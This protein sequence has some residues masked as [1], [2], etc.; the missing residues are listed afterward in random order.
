[1]MWRSWVHHR[2]L[3]LSPNSFRKY[4]IMISFKISKYLSPLR[5]PSKRMGPMITSFC[6]FLPTP[7]TSLCTCSFHS[8]MKEDGELENIL[9]HSVLLHYRSNKMLPRILHKII[10]ITF[11]LIQ[12]QMAKLKSSW[13]ICR[14]QLVSLAYLAGMPLDVR[15]TNPME[16]YLWY[17]QWISSACYM[18]IIM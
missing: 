12:Q 13:K 15:F 7:T 9:G 3:N 4:R 16:S 1:M 11:T 10:Q 8:W 18:C 5:F 6:T 14:E 2:R 17:L